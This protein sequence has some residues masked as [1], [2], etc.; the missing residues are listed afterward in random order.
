MSRHILPIVLVI[1][2]ISLI[3]GCSSAETIVAL[4]NDPGLL[5]TDLPA[6]I[7]DTPQD[8]LDVFKAGL[9]AAE[10]ETLDSFAESTIY[11]LDFTVSP[12]MSTLTGHEEVRYTNREDGALDEVYFRLFPN[13][14]GGSTV[15]SNLHVNDSPVAPIYEYSDSS[16]RVPINPALQP[17]ESVVIAMDFE[18]TVAEEMAG[19]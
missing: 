8:D 10:G 11:H 15:I 5:P 19:K 1:L 14:T 18:V 6:E 16:L 13:I 9:I 17:G 12:D 3:T 2:A 4:P 7:I